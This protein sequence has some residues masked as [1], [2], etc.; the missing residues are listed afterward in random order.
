[1]ITAKRHIIR[2]IKMKLLHQAVREYAAKHPDKTAVKDVAGEYSYKELDDLSSLFARAL[3]LKGIG[4]GD[5]VSV[6]VP[7]SKEFVLGA[8]AAAKAGAVFVPLDS[9]YPPS[10][11]GYILSL[12]ETKLILTVRSLWDEKKADFPE[13]RVIFMD[14][15]DNYRNETADFSINTEGITA[16]SPAMLIC[17]SGTTGNPKGIMHDHRMIPHLMDFSDEISGMSV[18]EGSRAGVITS[19]AFIVALGQILG[20][21]TRGASVIIA[22]EYARKDMAALYSFIKDEKISH[23]FIPSGM[24]VIMT[25]DY[26]LSGVFV[27]T[28]GDKLRNFKA[29]SP[30]N[31][32]INLYGCTETGHL[33][34][35]QLFGN[36]KNMAVGKPPAGTDVLLVDDN[37]NIVPTGEAGELVVKNAFMA[38]Q[39]F[40]LPELSREKWFTYEGE[41]WM[42][43]GDRA[44]CD[45]NG[46]YTI[47]GRID[48]M[49][50]LRGFRV[51]TG[52]VEAQIG[53]AINRLSL[54]GVT[55][56]VVAM[57]TVGGT[58]HLVC[59]YESK[60][61]IDSS[62]IKAE[63]AEYLTDYMIPDIWVRL[64]AFP[65][66]IN[67][68]IMRKE[69][70]QP[71]RQIKTKGIIDSEVLSRVIS[72]AAFV[73]DIDDYISPDDRFAELGGTSLTAMQ[74]AVKLGEQ[75]I[76]INTAQ[77]L[78][79]ESLRKIAEAAE[80]DYRQ[81]WSA[82]EYGRV[83]RSFAKRGET[84][85][86][87]L[88]ITAQQDEML[89]E[90]LIYP[91]APANTNVLCLQLD[92][93]IKEVDL[94]SALDVISNENEALRASVVFHDVTVI[95]QVITDRKIPLVMK[96]DDDFTSEEMDALRKSLMRER[97]DLQYGSMMSAVCVHSDG[98]SFLYIISRKIAV[99]KALLRQCVARLMLLLSEKY[100]D[101][102]SISGWKELLEM[103]LSK[104]GVSKPSAGPGEKK[105]PSKNIPEKIHAY[106]ENDGPKVVFIHSGNA[107]SEAYY[108]LA[109]LIGKSVSFAVIEQFNMYHPDEA[110]YGIKNIAANYIRILKEYQPRG[111]YII[112]GWCYGGIVAHEMACQLKAAGEMVTHLFMF[113]SHIYGDDE[114]L[115]TM[116]KG[117]MSGINRDYFETSPAFSHL[118][119]AG[120]LDAMIDN[121]AHVSEDILSHTPD[122]YTGDTTYFKAVEIP[123]G[124]KG[125]SYKYWHDMMAYEA[126]NFEKYVAKGHLKVI[127]VP[128]EHDSIMADDAALELIAPEILNVAA[129]IKK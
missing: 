78:Q 86:K 81:L 103:Q 2:G 4:Q 79:L 17:T 90:C 39:Y 13:D 38:R 57:K 22:P 53:N 42:K 35:K 58:D 101:D 20:P 108:R 95:Q 120:M 89:F 43:M 1:M 114:K 50:K 104:E 85:E 28:G 128:C 55:G 51:E 54:E 21:V 14:E 18:G 16:E 91:D 6:Y 75:G 31:S 40:K 109:E 23:I 59:Y 12:T 119:A 44:F 117:M 5:V 70:P 41:T 100:P 37:M 9:A 7:L 125:E 26:D 48:N 129:E 71:R 88:P 29:F 64:D 73:L 60:N 66:N 27:Y 126:G 69:L 46:D 97:N 76:K 34:A 65:R 107:G 3:Y 124:A 8:A 11:I 83:I 19:F 98:M 102:A 49:V 24:A 82:D 127:P 32:L 30:A 52:E 92:S 68:K 72:S 110:C 80:V 25:E 106:S 15:P 123:A 84:I 93:E 67:G 45:E 118:I 63:I 61:E 87:V 116:S 99:D 121:A 47:L 10:R 36:E 94:R 112:G 56:V 111:P 77:I 115:R 96:R 122:V 105:S 33:M 62:K 74:L 113:D